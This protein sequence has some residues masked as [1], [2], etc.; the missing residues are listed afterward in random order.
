MNKGGTTKP[1]S[2]FNRIEFGFFEI[3][4]GGNMPKSI[5]TQRQFYRNLSIIW[6]YRKE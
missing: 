1:N 6:K 5:D 4:G 2:S 3:I